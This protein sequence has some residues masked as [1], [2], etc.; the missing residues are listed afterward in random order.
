M[1][2]HKKIIMH[3]IP[4]DEWTKQ[5]NNAFLYPDSL[6]TEGFI[7]CATRD[8]IMGALEF[9]YKEKV[10]LNLLCIDADLVNAQIVYEDLYKTGED[11]PHIYGALNRNAVIEVI[12]FK[13]NER[14]VFEI[15][16]YS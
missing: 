2:F 3:L 9:L 6:K 7:H 12:D 10:D 4:G 1:E 8:Q 15:P 14:G 13:P 11:F 5:R 16:V